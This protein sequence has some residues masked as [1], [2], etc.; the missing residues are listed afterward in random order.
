MFP[1]YRPPAPQRVRPKQGARGGYGFVHRAASEI[2]VE[3]LEIAHEG[4]KLMKI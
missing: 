2:A 1:Y 4:L 3:S